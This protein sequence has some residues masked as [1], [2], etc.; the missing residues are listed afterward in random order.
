MKIAL[1]KNERAALLMAAS[2]GELDTSTIPRIEDVLCSANSTNGGIDW[3]AMLQEADELQ[4]EIDETRQAYLN[5]ENH[6][7][8]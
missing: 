8:G 6:I 4:T 1:T 3:V 7:F 5:S 2:T